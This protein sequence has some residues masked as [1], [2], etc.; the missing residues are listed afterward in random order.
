MKVL[1]LQEHHLEVEHK[2]KVEFSRKP[3]VDVDEVVESFVVLNQLESFHLNEKHL[4]SN[5]VTV[6][7]HDVAE[8]N[9]PNM[10]VVFEFQTASQPLYLAKPKVP[11]SLIDIVENTIG[12]S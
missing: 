8:I 10:D 5:I 4:H 2:R 11:V 6:K 7:I 3:L 12:F 1:P 9:Y